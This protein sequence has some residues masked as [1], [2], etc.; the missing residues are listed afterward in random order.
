MYVCGPLVVVHEGRRV[1]DELPGRQGGLL[2]AYLALNRARPVERD[3]AV[4]ALWSQPPP[5]ADSALSALLSKLRRVLGSDAVEGRSRIRLDLPAE[6]WIDLEAADDGLHRAESAVALG[7]WS[8]AWSPA[9]VAVHVT[10]R[11]FLDGY[12]G[13]WVEEQR[14]HVA[15]L[16][17]RALETYATACLHLGGTELAAAERAARNLT[18][19]APYRES[20]HRLLMRTLAEQGN[21]AEALVAYDELRRLLRDELGAS[22][23]P[24]TRAVHE[25]LL[26]LTSDP[27]TEEDR[28]DG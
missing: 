6:T 15:E 26:A 25:W 18:E 13:G 24:D 8:E 19:L 14:R 27:A 21:V 4:A 12:D 23:G 9:R 1:E 22:P 28:H 5:A 11:G 17:V 2:L 3:E 7:R 10:G 20:A 16:R